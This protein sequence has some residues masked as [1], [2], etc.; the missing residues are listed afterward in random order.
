[1]VRT[2]PVAA[3]TL[4]SARVVA[5]ST[6]LALH[7][8]AL[9][10][11]L[12]PATYQ[13]APPSRERNMV[14]T[15]FLPP[16]RV[17]NPPPPPVLVR[18]A[19]AP[20]RTVP[21]AAPAAPVIPAVPTAGIGATAAQVAPPAMAV[22]PVEGSGLESVAAVPGTQ[23]QYRSAPAPAYPIAALR[24]GEQGTVLL[25]VE[26]NAE[27]RPTAVGV[28]RSSGSRTLDQAARQQVLRRW[29]FV[30]AQDG[31]VPVPAVGLVPVN[32]SLPE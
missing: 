32:F 18:P 21:R 11:L 24:N 30:P 8:L 13:N 31:G 23:L 6:A 15:N 27:G 26:V 1:M 20:S 17:A 4:Q 3:P 28:E 5:W 19:P 9:M 14:L 12:I 10:L 7:L 16:P 25:R 29:Q 2:Y 22:A